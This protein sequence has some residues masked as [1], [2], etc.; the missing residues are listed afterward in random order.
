[1]FTD[2]RGY[3]METYNEL[4]FASNDLTMK[5]IQDNES[6][7]KKGVIRG[8]HVQIKKPQGK[9]VRVIEGSIFDVAV[10][11]R[12]GSNTFGQWYGVELSDRNYKQF[13]IPEGFAHG[14]VVLSDE[15]KICFKVSNYWE[16]ENE[17]GIP[18]DDKTIGI[19][20]PLDGINPIVAE[21]DKNYKPFIDINW[22]E[23]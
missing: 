9:L 19:N 14:Y 2:S 11:V 7:S 15:A 8:L 22:N 10:D 3:F 13:Y 17:I 23:L 4:D 18:W 6:K 21:K 20:W 16:P 1:M 12:K 5:F